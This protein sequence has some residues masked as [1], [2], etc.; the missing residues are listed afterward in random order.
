MSL[1]VKGGDFPVEKNWCD[2][3]NQQQSHMFEQV[4]AAQ[5][6]GTL[7][8]SLHAVYRHFWWTLQLQWFL[9]CEL[10][11]ALSARPSLSLRR[12]LQRPHMRQKHAAKPQ[13]L[14]HKQIFRPHFAASTCCTVLSSHCDD[15]S[16]IQYEA[17]F[18]LSMKLREQTF[19]C[20]CLLQMRCISSRTCCSDRSP[21]VDTEFLESSRQDTDKETSCM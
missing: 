13:V 15:P 3:S 4:L 2:R 5:G 17:L 8:V 19:Y 14:M 7:D 1:N 10:S 21:L 20:S 11:E 6:V 12:T 18:L 9:W 16:W